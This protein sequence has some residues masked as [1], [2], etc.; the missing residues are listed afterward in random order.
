MK[1]KY[2]SYK[3]IKSISTEGEVEG[4]G[5]GGGA[6]GGCSW[7]FIDC[8]L[9]DIYYFLIEEINILYLVII[10]NWMVKIAR[11]TA[12]HPSDPSLQ[13]KVHENTNLD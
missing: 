13:M 7:I 6:H 5:E 12:Q 1:K 2:K 10:L 11:Q 4:E 9:F 8:V 3:S